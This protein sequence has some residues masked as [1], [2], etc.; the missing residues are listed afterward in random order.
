M[1]DPEML[2]WFNVAAAF[3]ACVYWTASLIHQWPFMTNR[4]R[5]LSI[6]VDA[7]LVVVAYGSGEAADQN[8]PMGVRVFL[9]AVVLTALVLVLAVD[10]RD[11]ENDGTKR[12]R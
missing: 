11:R 9:A 5:R 6:C 7:L 4:A 10:F 1:F 2:R 8:A 12:H 3:A